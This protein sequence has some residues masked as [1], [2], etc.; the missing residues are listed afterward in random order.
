MPEPS[1]QPI[2]GTDVSQPL[3][4]LMEG[5]RSDLVRVRG[6]MSDFATARGWKEE[7][8]TLE[9]GLTCML[10]AM[11]N[12]LERARENEVLAAAAAQDGDRTR[13]KLRESIR[14]KQPQ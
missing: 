8:E 5:W 6:Q 2:Y 7:L 4:K 11:Y 10:V 12:T 3:S 14:A 1:R 9:G 13:E